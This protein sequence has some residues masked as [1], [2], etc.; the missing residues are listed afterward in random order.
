MVAFACCHIVIHA[1]HR[2]GNRKLPNNSYFSVK[3]IKYVC[4]VIFSSEKYRCTVI[5]SRAIHCREMFCSLQ[6]GISLKH[7]GFHPFLRANLLCTME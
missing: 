5:I 1:A 2:K 4:V 7:T 3:R 6:Q